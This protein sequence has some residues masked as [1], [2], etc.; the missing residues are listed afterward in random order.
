MTLAD[1]GSFDIVSMFLGNSH[2]QSP[3]L[4]LSSYLDDILVYELELAIPNVGPI[5]G[6][7]ASLV[8]TAVGMLNIDRM[9]WS[10]SRINI[11]AMAMDSIDYRVAVPEPS[12]L[13]L[14]GAGLFGLWFRR[15]AA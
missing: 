3:T 10:V 14:L 1:G 5:D 15:K 11:G 12:T 8:Y 4:F 9:E 6:P 2:F 7:G 13:G